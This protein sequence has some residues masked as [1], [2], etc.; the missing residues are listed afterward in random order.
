VPGAVTLTAAGHHSRYYLV[1]TNLRGGGQDAVVIGSGVLTP[2]VIIK[3]KY[4][5][6]AGIIPE[7]MERLI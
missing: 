4:L 3:F 5:L 2:G 1:I 7:E 6:S